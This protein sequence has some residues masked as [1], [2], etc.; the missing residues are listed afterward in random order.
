MNIE[1]LCRK[2]NTKYFPK[3]SEGVHACWVDRPY[4]TRRACYAI[5]PFGFARSRASG[6]RLLAAQGAYRRAHRCHHRHHG[7]VRGFGDRR[8]RDQRHHLGPA[9]KRP[10]RSSASCR[11]GPGGAQSVGSK[12]ARHF[13]VV[14][15]ELL[16]DC[17]L[18]LRSGRHKSGL[19]GDCRRDDWRHEQA[20]CGADR[21][22]V[23]DRHSPGNHQGHVCLIERQ[24]SE[25]A[26]RKETRHPRR[27]RRQGGR[28]A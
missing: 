14:Q 21:R 9:Q 3:Y 11:P 27:H 12:R 15:D 13:V 26:S 2:K 1:L 19:A 23:Q 10:G 16:P 17:I 18:K 25:S 5:N 24:D 7:G 8:H 22:Q 28:I 20:R 4:L 6:Q